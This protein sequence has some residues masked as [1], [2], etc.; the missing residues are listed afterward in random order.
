[1]NVSLE[2]IASDALHLPQDQRLTL[3]HRI[4]ASVEPKFTKAV[5]A[6][7]DTEIR[8][9]I[10]RYDAGLTHGTPAT[11]VFADLDAKLRQ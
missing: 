8:E 2:A 3:A 10:R 9:R 1:M 7:W 11:R 5:D 6:S 4:L